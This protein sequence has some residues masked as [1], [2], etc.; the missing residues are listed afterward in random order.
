MEQTGSFIVNPIGQ[1]HGNKLRFT[2]DVPRP[3]I[4]SKYF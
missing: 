4:Y 2:A 1:G 3:E